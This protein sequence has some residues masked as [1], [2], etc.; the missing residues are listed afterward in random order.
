MGKQKGGLVHDMEASDVGPSL[1]V[2]QHVISAV[3]IVCI[4]R[5]A[6]GLCIHMSSIPGGMCSHIKPSFKFG[7]VC[8]NWEDS[9]AGIKVTGDDGRHLGVVVF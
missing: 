1:W 4:G 9:G 7:E 5:L 8:E 3:A 2:G 6:G